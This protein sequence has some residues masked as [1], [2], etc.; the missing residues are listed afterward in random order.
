MRALVNNSPANLVSIPFDAIHTNSRGFLA[1]QLF[2]NNP[3][4]LT[5]TWKFSRSLS[6]EVL[7]PLN[8]V[9]DCDTDEVSTHLDGYEH[10]DRFEALLTNAGADKV[11]FADLN[12]L[13]TVLQGICTTYRRMLRA[14]GAKPS[15]YFKAQVLNAWRVVPFIDTKFMMDAF[16]EHGIVM[17]LERDFVVPLGNDPNSFFYVPNAAED[18]GEAV[19]AGLQSSLIFAHIAEAWG[20]PAITSR[21]SDDP[22]YDYEEIFDAQRRAQ[23]KQ[24]KRNSG[25]R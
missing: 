25:K 14:A 20:L 17:S 1:R 7:L 5:L 4:N 10:A 2:G 13:F 3:N 23:A 21:S 22:L 19:A 16:E 11:S 8:F 12:M 18:E 24:D 15:F 9:S 6:G